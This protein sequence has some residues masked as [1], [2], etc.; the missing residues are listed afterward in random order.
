MD[1]ELRSLFIASVNEL[2][3]I[4]SERKTI[5]LFVRIPDAIWGSLLFLATVGM[6][7]FGYQAGITGMSKIFQLIFL[8]LAFGLVIVLIADI[9]SSRPPRHFRVTEKPLNEVLEMMARHVP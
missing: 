9:N 1:G 8:P 3:S 4:T 7:A 2:I 6:F 5:A